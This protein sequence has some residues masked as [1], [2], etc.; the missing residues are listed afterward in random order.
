MLCVL[1]LISDSDSSRY[2]DSGLD[3]HSVCCAYKGEGEGGGWGVTC[4]IDVIWP[5]SVLL[6]VTQ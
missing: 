6:L 4:G 2:S 1:I 5:L 3:S